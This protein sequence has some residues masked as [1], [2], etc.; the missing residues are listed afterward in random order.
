MVG[1]NDSFRKRKQRGQSRSV[2]SGD[3][4][5]SLADSLRSP[6]VPCWDR[7][8]RAGVESRVWLTISM[9]LLIRV[10]DT[11]WSASLIVRLCLMDARAL[12]CVSPDMMSAFP[13][14][15]QNPA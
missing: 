13:R 14:L 8:D 6:L 1:S 9:R 3:G 7:T 15:R 5:L 2:G 10:G 4:V 11:V 12:L